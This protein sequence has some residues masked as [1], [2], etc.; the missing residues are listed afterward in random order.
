MSEQTQQE[1]QK[2]VVAFIAG[3]L[4]GGFLVWAFGVPGKDAKQMKDDKQNVEVTLNDSEVA[5]ENVDATEGASKPATGSA[6]VKDQAAGSSVA[7]LG[8]EF[9]T[10]EGWI[11]VRSYSN[12][13]LGPVLG[14]ARYSKSQGL[15]PQ[16]VE[17]LASTRSGG[18]YAVVFYTENGDRK[19]NLANDTQIDG[20]VQPFKAE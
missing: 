2:T 6:T 20:I 17:L 11:A 3:L 16:S 18:E 13:V 10:D 4:V 15:V 7:L 1:G 5:A 8:A 14:A 19:F 12:G 9:P